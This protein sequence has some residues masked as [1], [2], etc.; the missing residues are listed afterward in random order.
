MMDDK[1]CTT[2]H[3]PRKQEGIV[4]GDPPATD[5]QIDTCMAIL[6]S[7]PYNFASLLNALHIFHDKILPEDLMEMDSRQSTLRFK[8]FE[9][10][11][12]KDE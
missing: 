1:T 9:E 2:N 3:F 7:N 8:D 5:R 12:K 10:M 11:E 6:L 4:L